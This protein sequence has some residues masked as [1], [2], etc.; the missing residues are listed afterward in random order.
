MDIGLESLTAIG[1]TRSV[2]RSL[3]VA[4]RELSKDAKYLWMD[5]ISIDQHS[6]T[7]KASQIALMKVIYQHARDVCIWLGEGFDDEESAFEALDQTSA[8][9]D[10]AS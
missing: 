9:F 4:L 6:P 3:V 7:E 8:A 5:Q 10:D 1:E 2:T